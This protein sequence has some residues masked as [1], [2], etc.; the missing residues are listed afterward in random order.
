MKGAAV[1]IGTRYTPL[2][3][4]IT[5]AVVS[6]G[7]GI[8][9]D[10]VFIEVSNLGV[11]RCLPVAIRW[12]GGSAILYRRPGIVCSKKQR[13]PIMPSNL[14][15]TF[16]PAKLQRCTRIELEGLFKLSQLGPGEHARICQVPVGI[17]LQKLDFPVAPR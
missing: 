7:A 11:D 13:L 16:N 17:D 10:E 2:I 4:S 15:R 3:I 1:R 12:A 5:S 9:L 6:G 14:F 8:I